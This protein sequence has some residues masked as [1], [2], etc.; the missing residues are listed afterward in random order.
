MDN[1]NKAPVYKA[2]RIH[3]TSTMNGRWV[4]VIVS[5]WIKQPMPEDA[6]PNPAIR[7]PG[8]YDSEV[9][10]IQ[11]AMRYIDEQETHRQA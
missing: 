2:H 5:I 4:S 6:P 3:T 11:A 7:V 1:V 10:A 8:E 9:G